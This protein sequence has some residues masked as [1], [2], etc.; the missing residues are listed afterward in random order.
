MADKTQAAFAEL[1]KLEIE[2][3]KADLEIAKYSAKLLQPLYEQRKAIASKIEKFWPLAIEQLGDE[4]DQYFTPQDAELIDFLEA[5]HLDR[6][7]ADP[8]TFTITFTFKEN[9]F[10]E[11]LVLAKTFSFVP[12]DIVDGEEEE[13][14]EDITE[15]GRIM[16]KSTKV[17]IVWKKGKELTAQKPG[18]PV[19]FFSFFDWVNDEAGKD[20]FPKAH[21]VAVVIADELYPNAVKLFTEA[22][23][24]EDDGEED[25]EIDLEDEDDDD[26]EEEDDE[27][28][29]K[30]VKK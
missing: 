1:A 17:P 10:L 21:E 25:E 16:Y 5:I 2:F 13:D 15:A 8:R 22:V 24:E 26:D 30:R 14:S 6:D 18:A 7:A 4:I 20:V 19:S 29:K 9:P 3:E 28:P 27:P 11:T 23:N 12:K